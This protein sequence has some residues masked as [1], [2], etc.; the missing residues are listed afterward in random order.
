MFVNP[1]AEELRIRYLYRDLILRGRLRLP[2]QAAV[3]LVG[4][5][6]A[7][8]LYRLGSPIRPLAEPGDREGNGLFRLR[9]TARAP[10]R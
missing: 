2:P 10:D 6:C 3:P 7:Y 1:R 9:R 8:H 4:P 5:D